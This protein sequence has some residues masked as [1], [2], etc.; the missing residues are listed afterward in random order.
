VRRA[1]AILALFAVSA[2]RAEE[3]SA[4]S[5]VEPEHRAVVKGAAGA[6]QIRIAARAASEPD[7]KHRVRLLVT[8]RVPEG[9]ETARREAVL[10]LVDSG[11]FFAVDKTFLGSARRVKVTV[12]AVVECGEASSSRAQTWFVWDGGNCTIASSSFQRSGDRISWQRAPSAVSY[13]VCAGLP[14]KCMRVDGESVAIGTLGATDEFA[15]ITPL[16]AAGRGDP[17]VVPIQVSK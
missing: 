16:C 6:L 4:P 15:T 13:E 8:A 17:V 10:A 2:A 11:A 9:P 3:C 12:S 14:T 7:R 5:I 1:W